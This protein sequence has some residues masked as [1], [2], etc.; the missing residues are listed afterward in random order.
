[1]EKT[2]TDHAEIREWVEAIG[3]KPQIIESPEAGAEKDGLRIS[4][5]GDK[6][7][8]FFGTSKVARDANWDEFFK[9]FDDQELALV[10]LPTP[11]PNNL[12]DSYRFAPRHDDTPSSE[13]IM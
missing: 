8:T 2:T 6:R 13:Q 1:M 11:N 12:V 5:P 10:Y 7:D 9:L 3:G 4:F